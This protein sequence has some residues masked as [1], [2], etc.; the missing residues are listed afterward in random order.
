VAVVL[1]AARYSATEVLRNGSRIEIRALRPDDRTGL[2]AAMDRASAESFRRRFFEAKREFT[3]EEIA[4]FLNIDFIDH[5]T[6]VAVVE[7]G[8]R[9]MIVGG[10]RYIVTW[11]GQAEVAFAVVD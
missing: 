11:P 5:V 8:E 1:E 2:V 7:E 9:P 6:L 10:G 3:E 4:S